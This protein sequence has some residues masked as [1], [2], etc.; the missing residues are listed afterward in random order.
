[1]SLL[2]SILKPIARRIIKGGS[3]HQEESYEVF[4]QECV[5]TIRFTNWQLGFRL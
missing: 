1:M 3:V 2:Y 5:N 4:K